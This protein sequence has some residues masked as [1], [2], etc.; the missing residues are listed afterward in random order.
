MALLL[1][2]LA[3]AT[4]FEVPQIWAV[5]G[6]SLAYS[7]AQLEEVL[8]PPVSSRPLK[9][10]YSGERWEC[11]YR[12]GLKAAFVDE[13]RGRHP[14]L[15]VGRRFTSRG[16]R[17][18]ETRRELEASFGAPPLWDTGHSLGWHDEDR[19]VYVRF[20]FTEGRLTEVILSRFRLE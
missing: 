17:M 4:T 12:N 19:Q 15:L 6:L 10:S 14:R 9:A 5:D 8:G 2:W 3:L 16:Q 11:T 1:L 20:W 18:G 13:D 7:R